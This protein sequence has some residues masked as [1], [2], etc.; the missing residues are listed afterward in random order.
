MSYKD[1]LDKQG[2]D[3]RMRSQAEIEQDRFY[4]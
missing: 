2:R 1:I 3:K 4:A